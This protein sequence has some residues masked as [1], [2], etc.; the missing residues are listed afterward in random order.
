MANNKKPLTADEIYA[1]YSH[2]LEIKNKADIA[3]RCVLKRIAPI[4]DADTWIE[5]LEEMCD[6]FSEKWLVPES[7]IIKSQNNGD[8]WFCANIKHELNFIETESTFMLLYDVLVED[9]D[10]VVYT[11]FLTSNI[12][13]IIKTLRRY[14]KELE[15]KIKKIEDGPHFSYQTLAS[16]KPLKER[17]SKINNLEDNF[18]QVIFKEAAHLLQ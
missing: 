2:R 13:I 7:N 12:S 1:R 5:L 6:P 3:C 16:V 9:N 14:E 17:L 11:N 15:S 8:V 10:D 4:L 18:F